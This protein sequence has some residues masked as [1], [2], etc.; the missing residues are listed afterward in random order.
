MLKD[1]PTKFQ[2]EP[3][4]LCTIWTSLKRELEF[5]VI[6]REETVEYDRGIMKTRKE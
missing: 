5:I 4:H 1:L 3:Y 6:R 2:V